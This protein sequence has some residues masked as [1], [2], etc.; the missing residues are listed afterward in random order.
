[1]KVLLIYS[2]DKLN[3]YGAA[4]VFYLIKSDFYATRLKQL[5]AIYYSC[6]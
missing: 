1:M 6:K 3:S 5:I 2:A 4:T